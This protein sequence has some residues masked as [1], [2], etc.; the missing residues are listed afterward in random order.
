LAVIKALDQ[1]HPYLYG[2]QFIIRTDHS[3]L[4]RLVSFKFPE[5]QLA[6]WLEKIQQCNFR[7]QHRAGR[8]HLNADALS[9]R[10]CL[11][12]SC[13][14]CDRV[15]SKEHEA[16]KNEGFIITNEMTNAERAVRR[17]TKDKTPVEISPD[18]LVDIAS[19]QEIAEGQR[20]DVH[21]GPIIE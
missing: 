14:H 3:S 15:E 12:T 11:R 17:C 6:R 18:N 9:R 21:I 8:E 1:F 16:K 5:G 13:R 4:R 19:L 2:R 20:R 10:Q 7:V